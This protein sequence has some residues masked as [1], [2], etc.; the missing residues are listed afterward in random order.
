MQHAELPGCLRS[1]FARNK[2]EKSR[3]KWRALPDRTCSQLSEDVRGS[4][5][6]GFAEIVNPQPNPQFDMSCMTCAAFGSPRM[7]ANSRNTYSRSLFTAEAAGSSPV[8]PAIHPKRVSAD[9]TKTVADA[10]EA[11]FAPLRAVF[12]RRFV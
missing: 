8:V 10:N 4:V 5:R 7:L 12:T 3:I 6:Q 11:H 2:L 9:F 1:S